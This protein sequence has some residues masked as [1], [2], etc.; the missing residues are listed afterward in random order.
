[1]APKVLAM[2]MIFKGWLV[3]RLRAIKHCLRLQ[4]APWVAGKPPL[5]NDRMA[6]RRLLTADAEEFLPALVTAHVR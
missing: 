1:M 3:D 6:E 5:T 4:W 2:R